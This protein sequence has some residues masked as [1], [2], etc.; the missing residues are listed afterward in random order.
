MVIMIGGIIPGEKI[1][2][3]KIGGTETGKRGVH[4]TIGA[5][6]TIIQKPERQIMLL[7][8]AT[9]SAEKDPSDRL[10]RAKT[11]RPI[12]RA[13]RQNVSRKTKKHSATKQNKEA[14][15]IAD[16]VPFGGG[17]NAYFPCCKN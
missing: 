8:G 14:W 7:T 3:M 6:D 11:I 13:N 16:M 17:V 15:I 5:S 12:T 9:L 1:V 4:W 2:S 10:H